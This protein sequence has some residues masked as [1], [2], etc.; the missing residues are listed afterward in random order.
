MNIIIGHDPERT[1]GYFNIH[2]LTL[3]YGRYGRCMDVQTT[4]CAYWG[5]A[6]EMTFS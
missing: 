4:S 5:Q 1:R 6:A 2:A 3:C